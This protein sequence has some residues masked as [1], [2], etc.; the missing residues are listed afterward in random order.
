MNRTVPLAWAAVVAS[1]VLLSVTFAAPADDPKPPPA[2]AR[3]VGVFVGVQKYSTKTIRT[4]RAPEEDARQMEKELKAACGL[5]TTFLLTNERATLA[6]IT[7]VFTQKLPA[8][9]RPGDEVIVYWS[10]H[11]MHLP[12][13]NPKA[14]PPAR[15]FL[16]PHDG[17]PSTAESVRKTMVMDATFR[18]WILKTM[19][20][21]RVVVILDTCHSGGA[22]VARAGSSPIEVKSVKPP[23]GPAARAIAK[24]PEHFLEGAM[25]NT[26][27]VGRPWV[28]ASSRADQ[29]SYERPSGDHGVMTFFLLAALATE[30]KGA[31][32]TVADVAGVLG[33]RVP[34]YV[35]EVGYQHPQ[36]PVFDGPTQPIPL[37]RR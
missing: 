18:D 6:A 30:K 36:N 23:P 28:L 8:V 14:D 29:P 10:G 2:D 9:T 25:R 13:A 21:R 1:A 17:D 16:I 11:G 7:D 15:L 24:F 33:E 35:K 19:E 12:E 32:L 20:G 5:S 26:R 31:Q 27:A 22:V 4:L 3:R 34:A 37:I